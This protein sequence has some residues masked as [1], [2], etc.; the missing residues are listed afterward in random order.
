M[1]LLAELTSLG[2]RNCLHPQ[3]AD[4]ASLSLRELGSALR[5]FSAGSPVYEGELVALVDGCYREEGVLPS[6]RSFALRNPPPFPAWESCRPRFQS[7]IRVKDGRC[8][9]PDAL[10]C[11]SDD[12]MR[13]SR[14]ISRAFRS[15]AAVAGTRASSAASARCSY[16]CLYI[17]IYIYTHIHTYNIYI[18]IH[19]CMYVRMYVCMYVCMYVFMYVCMC[20]YIYIYVSLSIYLSLS[21]YIYIY[22]CV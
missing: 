2:T 18:Y 13:D 15:T 14:R 20:V 16:S 3:D 5:R 9:L 10:V 7:L 17:Y 6:Q 22:I 11:R 4:R 8:C 19:V 12:I 21:I 1:R